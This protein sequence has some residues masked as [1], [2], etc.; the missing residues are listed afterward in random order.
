LRLG[1]GIATNSKDPSAMRIFG[2][3]LVDA[4]PLSAVGGIVAGDNNLTSGTTRRPY[5]VEQPDPL[6]DLVA[7][8]DGQPRTYSEKDSVLLEGVYKNMIIKGDHTLNPGVYTID[9]GTLSIN[10]KNSLRGDGVMFVLKR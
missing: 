6:A 4:N 1:C 9:G 2:S 5:S 8:A 7:P 3:A 10:A